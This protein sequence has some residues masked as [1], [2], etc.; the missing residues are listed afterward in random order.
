MKISLF[1]AIQKKHSL[2]VLK[3]NSICKK[4]TLDAQN[5]ILKISFR[6]KKMLGTN[7]IRG[8][9]KSK[10]DFFDFSK[11]YAESKKVF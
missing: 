11:K 3:V 1:T 10:I 6:L 4:K 9:G 7:G 2:N 5:Y 8:G